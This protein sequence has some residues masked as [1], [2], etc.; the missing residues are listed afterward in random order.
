MPPWVSSA[1][2]SALPGLSAGSG[3]MDFGG[4]G[5]GSSATLGSGRGGRSRLGFWAGAGAPVPSATWIW[6]ALMAPP[7]MV[8]DG[9]LATDDPR[10]NGTEGAEPALDW[11]GGTAGTRP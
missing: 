1:F 9:P 3:P 2:P 4:E 8:E 11:P 7:T 5:G 6:G 10:T